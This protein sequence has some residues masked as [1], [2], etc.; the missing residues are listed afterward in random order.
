MKAVKKLTL[1]KKDPLIYI[2]TLLYDLRPG[3]KYRDVEHRIPS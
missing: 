1:C 2:Q 3:A